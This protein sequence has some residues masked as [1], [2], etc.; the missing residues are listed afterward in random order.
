MSMQ[1]AM[2]YQHSIWL[3][4]AFLIAAAVCGAIVIELLARRLLAIELRRRHN[5][6]GAAIFNIIGITYAVLLAFVA[7]LAWEG[8]TAA[9][10]ASHR[11]AAALLD[12]AHAAAGI[13]GP[14]RTRVRAALADYARTVIDEEWPEQAAGHAPRGGAARIEALNRAVIGAVNAEPA[15]AQFAGPLIEAA[16][17]LSDARQERLLAASTSIPPVTWFV[18]VVGGALTVAF[19][20]LL[21]AP[22]LGIQLAM[23]SCL[24]ASG[25]LVL[26]L[27]IALSEPFRG[28]FRVST[29]PYE[30]A[31]AQ[32]QAA[33]GAP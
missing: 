6:I 20:A 14:G 24:A 32:I 9:Q 5:D 26:L 25:A 30:R 13:A 7:M 1:A 22:S 10:A 27:I 12:V 29:Q 21:G 2:V 15:P 3:V 28:D 4:G 19:T 33:E 31:V 8:F 17:Q 16:R 11:E 23:S 18:L